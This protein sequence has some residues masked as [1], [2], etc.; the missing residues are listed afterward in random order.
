M[1]LGST[2]L[3][4]CTP[5]ILIWGVA[6]KIPNSQYNPLISDRINIFYKLG[7]GWDS[8]PGPSPIKCELS[9]HSATSDNLIFRDLFISAYIDYVETDNRNSRVC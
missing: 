3:R 4:T 6:L 9:N 2:Y 7:P 8:N 1:A 5:K